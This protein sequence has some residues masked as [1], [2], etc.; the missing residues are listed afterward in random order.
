[1]GLFSCKEQ[2]SDRGKKLIF[3]ES[4]TKAISGD[5]IR[6]RNQF[7]IELNVGNDSERGA[8][9]NPDLV[10]QKL[11]NLSGKVVADIGSGTGYFTFPISRKARKVLAIDIEQRY[12]DYIEDRKLEFPIERADAI[13]TRLTV[14]DEPNLHKNEVDAVLLVNVFYYL[15]DR[16]NYMT[17]VNN[18][19]KDNGILVLVDFKP[20]NL[21]VGPSE[22]KVPADDVVE[23]LKVSGFKDIKVDGE[24]LQ[25]QYIITAK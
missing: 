19:L 14:E 2:N 17:I 22:N 24:S 9:Q 16:T 18:A 3:H 21:P 7:E 8:W 12:L 1:M 23:V 15:N 25:Y 5:T 4:N 13:E 20:G 10:I 6:T 11:G